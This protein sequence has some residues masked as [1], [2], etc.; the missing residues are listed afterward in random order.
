LQVDANL[1]HLIQY[2][3]VQQPVEVHYF[4]LGKLKKTVIQANGYFHYLPQFAEVHDP[5]QRQLQ[6][7]HS[8]RQV[9]KRASIH[10]T[11][12]N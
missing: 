2:V 5:T 9:K 12:I 6:N 10:N 8:W 7:R 3:G 4:H 11:M 1:E